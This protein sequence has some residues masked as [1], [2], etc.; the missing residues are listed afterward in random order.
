MLDACGVLPANFAE[1]LEQAWGELDTRARSLALFLLDR[2]GGA[3][4]FLL[5]RAVDS[6]LPL[7]VRSA[8]F[9]ARRTWTG[10]A[11]AILEAI[12][13]CRHPA[14]RSYLY[15]AAGRTKD[16][17][18]LEA[19]RET[20]A[21]ETEA[22]CRLHAE[23]AAVLLGGEAEREKL[24]MRVRGAAPQEAEFAREQVLYVGEP[25][26]AKAMIP[27]LSDERVVAVRRVH[28]VPEEIRMCD[29]AV[30]TAHELGLRVVPPPQPACQVTQEQR[31]SA[32]RILRALL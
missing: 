18:S 28:L 22:P 13:K 2:L 3:P 24:Y 8:R 29:L 1:E 31:G 30:L 9:L 19:F 4:E 12:P 7:A 20:A 26:L 10:I 17:R 11:P 25:T 15:Q 6:A 27:W 5:R 14:A 21:K 23:A 16:R 32:E